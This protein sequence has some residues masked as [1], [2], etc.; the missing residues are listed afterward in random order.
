MQA[1]RQRKSI[2]DK[3]I[4][5]EIP[6]NFRNEVEIIVLSNADEKTNSYEN[7]ELLNV[8]DRIL[9]ELTVKEYFPVILQTIQ[10][11]I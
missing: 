3:N 2:V 8:E 1:I 5:V 11:M 9:P 4:T 6:D 10:F 7:R